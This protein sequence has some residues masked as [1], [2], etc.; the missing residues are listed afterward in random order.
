MAAQAKGQKHKP[1]APSIIMVPVTGVNVRPHS[2]H[3]HRRS[4]RASLPREMMP[5]DP[6]RGHSV[7]TYPLKNSA[8][9]GPG[10]CSLS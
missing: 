3:D 1:L 6:Q 4:P 10:P 2:L 8:S 7:R 5:T 9:C